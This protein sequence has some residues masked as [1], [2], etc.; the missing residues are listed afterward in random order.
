M[1]FLDMLELKFINFYKAP[2]FMNNRV[3]YRSEWK[4]YIPFGFFLLALTK[5]KKIVELGIGAG[6]SYFSFCQFVKEYKLESK[7][8]GIE[9]WVNYDKI[10]EASD[11]IK[12]LNSEYI[13]FSTIIEKDFK[14]TDINN[15]DF[16]NIDLIKKYSDI[17]EIVTDFIPRMSDTGI[18]LINYINDF[19]HN[20]EIS[21]YWTEISLEY[22]S[23]SMNFSKGLGVICVGKNINK[24]LNEFINSDDL[25]H[26]ES[27]FRLIGMSL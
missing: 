16:L 7:C 11:K 15:I 9:N 4:E 27:I 24:N 1:K 25:N 18:I 19:S 20:C 14:D 22:P 13:N 6:T 2:I 8:Y 5:P 10:K 17:K 12:E 26:Y 21:R 3:K 23:I